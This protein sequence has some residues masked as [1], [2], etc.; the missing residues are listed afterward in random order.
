MRSTQVAG[1]DLALELLD[2]ALRRLQRGRERRGP[3]GSSSRS[4]RRVAAPI[5]SSRAGVAS[6]GG[7]P[8]DVAQR[9]AACLGVLDPLGRLALAQLDEARDQLVEVSAAGRVDGDLAQRRDRHGVADAPRGSSPPSRRPGPRAS[10]RVPS[11]SSNAQRYTRAARLG[12]GR[13]A[14]R[15]PSSP[16]SAS[17]PASAAA[18]APARPRAPRRQNRRHADGRRPRAVRTARPVVRPRRSG[19]LARPGSALASLPRLAAA[20][21]RRARARRRHRNGARRRRAPPPRL[22]VTGL[23]Q[24]AEMLAERAPAVR[25]PRRARRGVGRVAALRRRLLRPPHVHVPAPLRRRPGRDARRARAR[26]ATRAESSRRSS[27]ASRAGWRGRC[28]ELYVRA[29]LP[30][31]GRVLRHGWSEVGDFLG[32]SIR[33]FWAAYPLE[34]QLELWARR[35]S[36]RRGA[37][38]EPRRRRRDLGPARDERPHGQAGLVRARDGRLARLRD[39]APPAVHGL[40]PLVRRDRRLPRARRR[41]GTA[42]RRRRGV[43]AR[44]RDRRACARRAHGRPLRTSIPELRPRRR[45]PRSRSAPRARSASSARSCSALARRARAGRRLPRPR[46]QPRAPRRTL[47]LGSLVRPRLG[48]LPGGLRLCRG[49]GRPERRSAARRRVRRPP[50]A[51]PARALEPRP[52]SCGAASLRSTASSSCATARASRST[53][54][55]LIA[56]EERGL[57]LLAAASVVLAAALVAFRL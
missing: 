46:L 54:D 11:A 36:R 27:S 56:A 4:R 39:A 13:R 1:L 47:P 45:S 23:D 57:R 12:L 30:L 51:R 26:R 40:A 3:P 7:S 9:S 16:G 33:E 44:R 20:T 18:C 24:S 42:R 5:S 28:W 29:G 32:G 34:R 35:A 14:R 22:R 55:R 41:L 38:A 8:S 19:A 43:R 50:L 53:R 52:A 6:C 17:A 48:R 31:A 2:G 10:S 37:A 15:T 49:R 21:R 25:R